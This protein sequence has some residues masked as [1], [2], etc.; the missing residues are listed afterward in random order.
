MQNARERRVD[1]AFGLSVRLKL[2]LSYAGFLMLTGV[3]MLV[4]AWFAG[5]YSQSFDSLIQEIPMSMRI[6]IGDLVP[7]SNSFILRAFAPVA[8]IVLAFLLL[9]GLVG[10]GFSRGGCLRP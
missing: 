1:R 5:Q 4:G 2:T 6:A 7:G 3:L 10:G 8:V 9:F